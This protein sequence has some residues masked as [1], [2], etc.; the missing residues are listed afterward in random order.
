MTDG[1]SKLIPSLITIGG[2]FASFIFLSIALKKLPISVAYAVWTGIGTVGTVIFGMIYLGETVD[3]PHLIC[4]G[5]I[6]CGI[7]GLRLLS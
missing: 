2:M 1:F 4:V 3:A 5:M 7:A 6:I